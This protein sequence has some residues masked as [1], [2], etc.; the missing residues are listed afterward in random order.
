M[1]PTI[2]L[3]FFHLSTY[4]TIYAIAIIL[5]AM[6]VFHRIYQAGYPVEHITNGSLLTIMGGTLGAFLFRGAAVTIQLV[7][8]TGDLTWTGGSS[9]IGMLLGGIIT[10]YVYIRKHGYPLGHIFDLG[11]VPIPLGQA[12]GRLGCLA[13]GCCYGKPT[14]SWIGIFL[15]NHQG[16]WATRY[17][18][19]LM[20]SAINF[21]IFLVLI[22]FETH[23]KKNNKESWPFSGFIFLLYIELFSI[24]RFLIEFLRADTIPLFGSI[25]MGHTVTLSVFLLNTVIMLWKIKISKNS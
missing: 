13:A 12:I 6:L 4:W 14:S 7:F 10:A 15:R 21:G 18:T 3:G 23:Q 11:I 2:D 1:Y 22:L 20:S 5:G 8:S 25:S 24:H 16:I 9:V 17:P 19:Q